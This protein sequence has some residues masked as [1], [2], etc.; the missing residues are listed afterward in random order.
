M[1]MDLSDLQALLAR[2]Q[3]RYSSPSRPYC[4]VD[5][6]PWPCVFVTLARG[7]LALADGIETLRATLDRL[8]SPLRWDERPDEEIERLLSEPEDTRT[9]A[10]VW[11]GVAVYEASLTSEQRVEREMRALK[12]IGSM[13]VERGGE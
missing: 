8:L 13:V 2:H 3:P 10:E 1:T 4:G 5:S 11:A 6:Q 12:R 9:D 7:Q